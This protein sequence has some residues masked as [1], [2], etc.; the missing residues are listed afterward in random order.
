MSA[1]ISVTRAGPFATIQDLGRFGMLRHGISA[2]GPMDRGAFMRAGA[3]LGE[4]GT[5]GIEI[6]ESGL[7][8][9][10]EDGN[11]SVGVDGGDFSFKVNGRPHSWPGTV[12][13]EPGDKL[14]IAPG[15]WGNYGYLRFDAEIDVP[16][17]LGSR[18]TN[19]TVGL[20]GLEGRALHP[21]DRLQFHALKGNLPITGKISPT[22]AT[23]GPIRIIWGL[24][25]DL[26]PTRLRNAFLEAP[27]V[28]S[29]RLDRMGVRLTD[30]N[31]IFVDSVLSLVS[32]AIV[33]GDI[34]ILGDGTPIVLMRDHQPTGGYPRIATIL[35]ADLDRFAQ[36]RPGSR[37]NF[38]SI[39]LRRAEAL[40]TGGPPKS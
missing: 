40:R 31:G 14:D 5:A 3:S 34:Q 30:P 36:M 33:P 22:P 11:V 8:F 20:G 32:D 28:I 35:S 12:D 18:S 38:Q 9:T 26:F 39:S 2:S 1:V 21:G 37:I 7:A 15:R 25:A 16:L 27:F 29:P 24:H 19:S 13:L 23:D 6:T 10:V 4:A 17:I